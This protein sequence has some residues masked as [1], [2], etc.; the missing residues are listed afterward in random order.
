MWQ[1]IEYKDDM[2]EEIINMTVEEYGPEND[3]SQK[4]FIEHEYFQNPMGHAYMKLDR[5]S[6]V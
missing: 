5:K 3:I 4:E 6:V 2:L 1:S